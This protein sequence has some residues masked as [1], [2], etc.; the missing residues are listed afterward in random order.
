MDWWFCTEDLPKKENGVSLAPDGRVR[1]SHTATNREP[2]LRLIAAFKKI[3]RRMG[4]HVMLTQ[5]MP[6]NAV[7]HQVGHGCFWARRD[8]VGA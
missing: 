6:I 3:L 7:A 4:F 8:D 1:L 5:E 2:H